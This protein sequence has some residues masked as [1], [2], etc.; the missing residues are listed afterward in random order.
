MSFSS[1]RISTLSSLLHF[2]DLFVTCKSTV[3]PSVQFCRLSNSSLIE[4]M[5]LVL[6]NFDVIF[7]RPENLIRNFIILRGARVSTIRAETGLAKQTG[8]RQP[9]AEL[10][11]RTLKFI[12]KDYLIDVEAKKVKAGTNSINFYFNLQ[13]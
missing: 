11:S 3:S 8:G 6:L 4:T 9:S 2:V 5:F 1:K 10:S 13:V 12:L 7:C